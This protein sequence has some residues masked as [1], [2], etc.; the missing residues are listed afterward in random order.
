LRIAS[1]GCDG[2]S[3]IEEGVAMTNQ[4][5]TSEAL[6]ET[7]ERAVIAGD[8]ADLTPEQRAEYYTAVCRSLGLNPLTKPFE[9]LTLNGKLRLY[10]LRDCGDQLR[11]LHGISIYITN[12]ERMGDV[13]IVTARAKDRTGREDEST[14][15]VALGNLKGD[16]LCNALMKGETKAKRRVTLSIAGLGWLDET[17]LETIPQRQVT[18]SNVVPLPEGESH[19]PA[20]SNGDITSNDVVPPKA[21][22]A[23]IALACESCHEDREAFA[24]RV[25]RAMTLKEDAPITKRVLCESMTT[26]AYRTVHA[27]Y[28]T[29]YA[30]LQRKTTE[31]VAPQE[32]TA[33]AN[34][35]TSPSISEP[36]AA[37]TVEDM[38]SVPS[39]AAS[40]S[41]ASG[42]EDAAERDRQRLRAEVSTW[43]L[44]VPPEEVE[45]IIQRHSY[46]KARILLW[47]CCKSGPVDKPIKVSAAD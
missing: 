18:S 32:D 23:L 28:E 37:L 5:T 16:S 43:D 3:G 35:P 41:A 21:I 7:I 14:G 34:H 40:S 8:L 20:S 13:Y 45:Y 31:T 4:P 17:E 25:R 24:T 29:L 6:P 44:R 22:E 1:G 11:R 39:P 38:P 46:S 47:K 30:Q 19:A 15:A 10:A 42:P 26:E 33:N 36:T 12:R 9:F 2:C 27:W